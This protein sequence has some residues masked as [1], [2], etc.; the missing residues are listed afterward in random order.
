MKL[1]VQKLRDGLHPSEVVVAVAT[2]SGKERLVVHSGTF[3]ENFV[4]I[5]YPIEEKDNGYLV[6]LPNETDT[7]AWRVWVPQS[8]LA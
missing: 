2:L 3:Q 7:G 4:E 6:E 5:G 1:K 8:E